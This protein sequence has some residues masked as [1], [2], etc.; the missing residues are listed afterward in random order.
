MAKLG[1]CQGPNEPP[2][3]PQESFYLNDCCHNSEGAPPSPPPDF[4][5]VGNTREGKILTRKNSAGI[6]SQYLFWQKI[7][8]L[9]MEEIFDGILAIV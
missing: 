4:F 5:T 2:D 3:A 7:L 8:Q 9:R 6:L 1:H